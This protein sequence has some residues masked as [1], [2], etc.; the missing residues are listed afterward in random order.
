[1]RLFADIPHVG[2]KQ[3]ISKRERRQ[4]PHEFRDLLIEMARAASPELRAAHAHTAD[5]R[6]NPMNR[7]TGTLR[8]Y[9]HGA[10][11]VAH[12]IDTCYTLMTRMR[13]LR[14]RKPYAG[15]AEMYRKQ[16]MQLVT[17]YDAACTKQYQLK[18]KLY[19]YTLTP[20]NPQTTAIDKRISCLRQAVIKHIHSSH[21]KQRQLGI[22]RTRIKKTK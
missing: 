10:Q 22:T 9:V 21:R 8:C 6:N 20:I 16:V 19:Y 2:P 15:R 5:R 1:M 3:Q 13:T 17:I 12:L 18:Q 11:H 4:A 7:G 14:N